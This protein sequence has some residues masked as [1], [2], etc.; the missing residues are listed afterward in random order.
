[1]GVFWTNY[2]KWIITGEWK[3]NASDYNYGTGK[4]WRLFI[5]FL[6]TEGDTGTEGDIISN[7]AGSIKLSMLGGW[8]S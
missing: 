7:I 4:F 3:F 8:K 5:D 1:M 2:T 6:G